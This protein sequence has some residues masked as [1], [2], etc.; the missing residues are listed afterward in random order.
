MAYIVQRK[1]RFYV[2]AYNGTDPATGRERRRWHPAGHSRADAEAIAARLECGPER[3]VDVA[4][5]VLRRA[6][7]HW[8]PARLRART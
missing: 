7:R 4:R 8:R 3:G 1:D 6:S 5:R 2:V